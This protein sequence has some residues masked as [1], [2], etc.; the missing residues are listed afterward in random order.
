MPS[1]PS[2]PM[3][4]RD[5]YVD[6]LISRVESD[7]REAITAGAPEASTRHV[8][9]ILLTATIA[10]TAIRF[11]QN[12]ATP[13][14]L[15]EWSTPDFAR[16]ARWSV[17]NI[18]GYLLLPWVAIRFLLGRRMRDFGLTTAGLSTTWQPYAAL[19]ALSLP[20]VVLASYTDAF[21]AKYPFY[22]LSPG[23][24]LWPWMLVWWALYLVQFLGVEFFFRGF[25]ALGLAPRFGMG[26]V[27]AMVA[28]YV[29]IH[30][31]KP[32]L[33]AVAAIV[34]GVVLGFLVLKTKSI[35]WGVAVHVSIAMLMDLL[36]L[37]HTGIL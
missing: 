29:M 7:S 20:F 25:L 37:W 17:V 24:G 12:G 34:G 18:A 8:A 28:P 13:A 26:A 4:I 36:A 21:Q 2:P 30:F 6:G 5:R 9:V 1:L 19:A 22:D 16:L 23:E 35:W 10:L 27:F 15:A 32:A 3:S 14:W 11:G 31:T 33:E